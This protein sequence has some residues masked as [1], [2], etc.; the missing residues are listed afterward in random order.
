MEWTREFL[1]TVDGT[2]VLAAF[3]PFY[4]STVKYRQDCGMQSFRGFNTEDY[5]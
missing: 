1:C 5:T 2:F 3:D 4:W